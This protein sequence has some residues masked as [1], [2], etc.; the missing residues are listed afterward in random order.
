MLR[1]ASRQL[2]RSHVTWPGAALARLKP[3]NKDVVPEI[4]PPEMEIARVVRTVL[5]ADVVESVRLMQED[6]SGTVQRWRAFV[7]HVVHR[8]L[9]G[10][11]GRLVKSLGDGL[12]L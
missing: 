9:P 10:Q 8:L 3:R 7:D 5:V 12:M 11:D 6:E 2:P 4:L 1:P